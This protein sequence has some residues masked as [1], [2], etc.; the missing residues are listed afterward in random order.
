MA[1]I[2]DN[3][4]KIDN[5]LKKLSDTIHRSPLFASDRKKWKQECTKLIRNTIDYIRVSEEL[6]S[7]LPANSVGHYVAS[8]KRAKVRKRLFRN[9]WISTNKSLKTKEEKKSWVLSPKVQ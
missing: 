3:E 9:N 5:C 1:E 8:V 2:E 7:D 4:E 6:I